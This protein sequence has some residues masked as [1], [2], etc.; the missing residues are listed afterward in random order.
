LAT[1]PFATCYRFDA[2]ANKYQDF[3]STHMTGS[4]GKNSVIP[5]LFVRA[6]RRL[7]SLFFL[8]GLASFLSFFAIPS[9]PG[10]IPVT[11]GLVAAYDFTGNANDS[12][13]GINGAIFGA[14]PISDR[15]GRASNAYA[16]NG[17]SSYIEI[18]DHDVFSV[19]T[20]GA[21][22][23]SGWVRPDGTSLDAN[24]DLLFSHTDGSGYVYWMGKGVTGQHEWAARIYSADNTE[25][26]NRKN[27]MSFYL[28]NPQ[29][30]LGAGSYFQDTVV[31]GVWI[32]YVAVVD[33]AAQTI[34]WYKNGVFRDQD[35]FAPGS[36]FPVTPANGTE[37]FRIGTRA[38]ESFFAGAVDDIRVYNRVLSAGEAQALF[39]E[40]IPEPTSSVLIAF[41]LGT[42]A[43]S[44]TRRKI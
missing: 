35:S 22:S 30:G 27:R 26:P 33:A 39:Q 25:V 17:S 6:G 19:T 43:F 9:S 31:P 8:L 12:I 41:G 44:R 16:F 40:P 1:P 15:F 21:F 7:L 13:S 23:I 11:D 32:H 10:S 14:T 20:T 24:G 29:G 36:S 3:N 34:T 2:G 28:F 42:I 4:F 37:P 18:P 5:P 38:F